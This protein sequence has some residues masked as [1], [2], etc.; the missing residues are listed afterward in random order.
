VVPTDIP[1]IQAAINA[2]LP[3]QEIKVLVQ[4]NGQD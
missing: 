4:R 3:G 1:T 2:A